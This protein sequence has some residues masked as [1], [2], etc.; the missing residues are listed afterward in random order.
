MSSRRMKP[1]TRCQQR[2][3]TCRLTSH[4]SKCGECICSD[5]SCDIFVPSIL[6]LAWVKHEEEQLAT[7]K[8]AVQIL[9]AETAQQYTDAVAHLQRVEMEQELLKLRGDEIIRRGLRNV[10]ELKAVTVFT[11]LEAH[12]S[13]WSDR[14]AGLTNGAGGVPGANLR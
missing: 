6:D 2:N 3:F 1:C 10:Y 4:S 7:E 14:I 11:S 5:V 13:G 12:N 8:I 9:V